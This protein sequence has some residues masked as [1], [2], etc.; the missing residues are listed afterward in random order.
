MGGSKNFSVLELGERLFL[1][2]E[3]ECIVI[4]IKLFIHTDLYC[5]KY[6]LFH[7]QYRSFAQVSA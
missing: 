5:K 1:R 7:V 2:R 3:G 6:L 4:L